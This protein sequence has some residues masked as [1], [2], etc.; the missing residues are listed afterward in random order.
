MGYFYARSA[1]FLIILSQISFAGAIR[2]PA[3]DAEPEEDEEW[4]ITG[5][6]CT[7]EQ[8]RVLTKDAENAC[9]RVRRA[10]HA[11]QNYDAEI[12]ASFKPGLNMGVYLANRAFYQKRL[13]NRLRVCNTGT[14]SLRCVGTCGTKQETDAYVKV[15][16]GYVHQTINICDEFFKLPEGGRET[17]MAHEFGRL[18]NIGDAEG[19][20]TNNI[21]V[22]DAILD[23]LSSKM[24]LQV[25][26]AKKKKRS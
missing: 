9:D 12:E 8:K 1:L 25:L 2:A 10:L 18:E 14:L 21:Y 4:G 5:S 19:L 26:Q 3:F 11:M 24:M 22:W 7:A 6:A 16:F 20:E 17:T 15:T 13:R 23:G